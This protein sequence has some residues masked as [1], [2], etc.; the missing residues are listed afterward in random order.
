MHLS[1]QTG[2][3]KGWPSIERYGF[4]TGCIKAAQKGMREDTGRFLLL[5]HVVYSGSDVSGCFSNG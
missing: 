4:I 2:E 3:N 5:L 1:A